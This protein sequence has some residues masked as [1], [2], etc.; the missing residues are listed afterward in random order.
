MRTQQN[1]GIEQSEDQVNERFSCLLLNHLTGDVSVWL[2][3]ANLDMICQFSCQMMAQVHMSV[4]I[5]LVAQNMWPL[6]VRPA[7]PNSKL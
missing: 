5:S 7:Q 6:R 4:Q 3:F 2:Q 1:I